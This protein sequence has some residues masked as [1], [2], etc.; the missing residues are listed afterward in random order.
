MIFPLGGFAENESV[1]DG[2]YDEYVAFNYC[3]AEN[4]YDAMYSESW[5]EIGEIDYIFI[6][7]ICKWLSYGD[8]WDE[9]I[10]KIITGEFLTYKNRTFID[11]IIEEK[12]VE[13]A[14]NYIHLGN[15]NPRLFLLYIQEP[16]EFN[17]H[18]ILN[19]IS[20][21]DKESYISYLKEI[22]NLIEE[23]YKS[24]TTMED[25]IK[26]LQNIKPY[27]ENIKYP[28]A[29]GKIDLNDIGDY[30]WIKHL[31]RKKNQ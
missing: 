24:L 25:K 6:K 26:M 7:N 29:Y 18:N 21:D 16:K 5:N 10:Q 17:Q 27:I 11:A 4:Y 13:L 23:K 12:R 20:F 19:L 3:T 1:I 14:L 9:M 15:T 30:H 28:K 22:F 31:T 2:G 8:N